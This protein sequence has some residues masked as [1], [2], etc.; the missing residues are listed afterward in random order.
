MLSNRPNQTP[1]PED[2][3]EAYG[4]DALSEDETALVDAHLDQ[5]VRCQRSVG[6]IQGSLA[7]LA[8]AVEQKPAPPYLLERVMAGLPGALTPPPPRRRAFLPEFVLPSWFSLKGLALPAAA[9]LVIALFGFSLAMNFRLS[10][11]VEQIAQ[12]NSTV[13]AQMSQAMRETARMQREAS[14]L[15]SRL[16]LPGPGN[17]GSILE[18]AGTPVSHYL[19]AFPDTQ[20]VVMDSV[21]NEQNHEGLLLVG[22]DGM[23]ATMMIS[24]LNPATSQNPYLVWLVR[25]GV[26]TPEGK[27]T[28]D[29][30]GWG[31]LNIT[32]EEPVFAFDSVNVTVDEGLTEDPGQGLILSSRIPYAANPP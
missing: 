12:E 9:A 4:L 13:T 25:G 2:L 17:L 28:V 22:D 32:M 3:F 1:H 26:W 18:M 5:C 27:L 30:S 19:D 21:D 16:E 14:A 29:P 15:T 23:R 10:G 8:A 31:S 11:Q 7:A 6:Q 24:N 20:P